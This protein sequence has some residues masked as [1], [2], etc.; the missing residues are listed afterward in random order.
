[1]SLRYH[2][3]KSTL[4][5]DYV[6]QYRLPFDQKKACMSVPGAS[7][8]AAIDRILLEAVSPMAIEVAMGV[9]QELCARLEEADR[10]RQKQV[11]R[12]RYEASVA[13]RRYKLVDPS[14]RLVADTLEAEWNSKIRDHQ[15]AI[16]NYE[17]Q[18]A[19]DRQVLS[20]AE[21]AQI[22]ELATTFPQLWSDPNI[23]DREKKRIVHLILEDVTL[24]R[25]KDVTLLIRFKGGLMRTVSVPLAKSGWQLTQT[26]LE[27]LAEIDRLLNS[28]TDR[29]VAQILNERGI[30]T[31][32]G[33]RFTSEIVL[34]LRR[35]HG[36]RGRYDRLRQAGM[37]TCAELMDMFG[38]GVRRIAAAR[39]NGIL[40]AHR[41]NHREY[42][43]EPPSADAAQKIPRRIIRRRATKKSPMHE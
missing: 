6:C 23:S 5:P 16:A 35:S 1:M 4:V 7:V 10:L 9:Q 29:E 18:R 41:A 14:N 8:D 30:R 2:R 15:E 25:D 24:R 31:G 26:P 19:A 33:K 13:E 40:R 27:T 43:Y 34:F 22:R 12:A 38:A 32:S 37:L 42:L 21:Q 17:R 3:R 20:D 36:I 39:R 28:H 11:E